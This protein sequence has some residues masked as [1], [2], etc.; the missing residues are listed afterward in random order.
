M[1]SLGSWNWVIGAFWVGTR[2]AYAWFFGHP[3]LFSSSTDNFYLSWLTWHGIQLSW[4][5]LSSSFQIKCAFI[6]WF[7]QLFLVFIKMGKLLESWRKRYLLFC[8]TF[9][10]FKS[11]TIEVKFTFRC[12]YFWK[13]GFLNYNFVK[14]WFL[15]HKIYFLKMYSVVVFRIVIDG[16]PSK[17]P[18]FRTYSLLAKET[19]YPLLVTP[20]LS[21]HSATADLYWL[22]L[23]ICLLWIFHISRLL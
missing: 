5:F 21:L 2:V 12:D 9:L 7:S 1:G 15:H 22:S 16:Q 11:D 6:F 17:Q 14:V 4:L 23:G 20:H 13:Y 3:H 10:Y 19:L 18:S 8:L